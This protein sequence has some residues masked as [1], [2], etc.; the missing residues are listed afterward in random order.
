MYTHKGA[1]M[2]KPDES[3]AVARPSRRDFLRTSTSMIPA[4]MAGSLAIGRSAHAGGNDTLRVGLV[5]CGGRGCGAAVNAMNADRGVRLVAMADAFADRLQSSR[6]VLRKRTPDQVAVDDDHCFAGFDGYKELIASGVDVVLLASPPHFRPKHLKACI[7]ADKHVFAEKPVG[8]DAPGVRSVLAT[9]EEAKK[10]NLNIVS[11]LCWRYNTGIRETIERVHDGAI[12]QI[13]A[14]QATSNRGPLW[15]RGHKPEWTEMEFQLRNWYYF[16]W[17]SG[18]F[19]VEQHVHGLDKCAWA[20]HDEPPTKAWAISG[21]Q[22]RTDAKWGDIFDQHA[23]VYEYADGKRMFAF[24]RQQPGCYNEYS[25]IFLGTKGRC[26][27]QKHRIE[28][29]TNW[30]Y[31]GPKEFGKQVRAMH[32]IEQD[33]FFA[34]IRA[35]E[36]INNGHY[37]CQSTLLGILGRTVGYT[38]QAISWDEMLNSKQDLSP[39]SYAWDADPPTLPEEDGKYPVAIPGVT[40][41]V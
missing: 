11:G 33:E 16:T 27:L 2:P 10:K 39:K 15:H 32:Q 1:T 7:D 20:I 5:G 36:P 4:A 31:E 37:M 18:D 9:C 35:G 41:F 23:V 29:E 21:R 6:A 17:L 19:N 3:Q 22:V 34:A 40:K 12:G 24:T 14:M 30:H 28:G 13:V 8:V 38:G 26:D 25:E